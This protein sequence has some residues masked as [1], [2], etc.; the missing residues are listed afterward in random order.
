VSGEGVQQA[1][2]KLIEG[3]I[4]KI[5][6]GY[7]EPIDFDT[8]DILFVCSGAFVGLDEVVRKNR[9]KSG[10]GIGANINT[11]SSFSETIK[12]V[13]SDDL[14]KYGLIPEFVGRCPITVVFDDMTLDT[15]V[16]I[17]KEP[18]NSIVEQFKV[19][20]KYEGVTLDFDD[21]YLYNVAEN[22]LKQKIGARGLRSIMEKDL[23]ATQF[24]LPKLAKNG[25]NKIFVD[26]NGS[27]KHV[28]KAAKR[29]K[30]E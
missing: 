20:F 25:V 21:K 26:A 28:Y 30:N 7:D 14:I 2:L 18:K 13:R 27:I 6:D 1:L 12:D 4:I 10:I 11:K 8:K 5:D 15:L 17:L 23:E 16:K 24:V 22:A 19:L 29:A 3:T 9:S